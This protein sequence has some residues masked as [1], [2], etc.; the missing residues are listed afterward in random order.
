[1]FEF[2][3]TSLRYEAT[4]LYDQILLDLFFKC[5]KCIFSFRASQH[6]LGDSGYGILLGLLFWLCFTT[7]YIILR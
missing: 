2:L 1:M 4:V 5:S 3:M 7:S 6:L